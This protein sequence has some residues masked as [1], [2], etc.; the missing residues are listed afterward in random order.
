MAQSL[1]EIG[2]PTRDPQDR[3]L[4]EKDERRAGILPLRMLLIALL[5]GGML[6]L[7]L[8]TV[9]PSGA[10]P[11]AAMAQ[12]PTVIATRFSA[13]DNLDGEAC[14]LSPD[15]YAYQGRRYHLADIS[16]PRLEDARC[17][18]EAERAR[19]GRTALRAM[20]NG[21]AFEARSDPTDSDP[22]ARLLVRDG[23]S[24]GQLM[25]LK[26]HA[27]PWTDKPIDWCAG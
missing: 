9:L 4:N 5:A 3:W 1:Y 20:M 27:R 19:R 15:S 25:I 6:L 10:E 16:V 12:G 24:F 14:V 13:C 21:G 18:L 2:D 26:H 23:V 22:G 11:S 7:L 17:P 8:R